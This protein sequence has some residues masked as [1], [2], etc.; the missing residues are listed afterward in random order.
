[1]VCYSWPQR[2]P[3]V[4][5]GR[6]QHKSNPHLQAADVVVCQVEAVQATA[7]L[8]AA[9]QQH[10]V[11]AGKVELLQADQLTQACNLSDVVVS[12]PQHLLAAEHDKFSNLIAA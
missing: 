6:S 1:M 4:S 11:I 2:L 10:N 7:L 8:Q 5:Q 3:A 9:A 12:N